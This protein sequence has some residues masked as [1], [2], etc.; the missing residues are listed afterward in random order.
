M[1]IFK[2]IPFI[3]IFILLN[4]ILAIGFMLDYQKPQCAQAQC[5]DMETVLPIIE[6]PGTEAYA[7]AR[8]NSGDVTVSVQLGQSR[9]SGNTRRRICF[10]ARTKMRELDNSS[11]KSECSLYEGGNWW[12]VVAKALHEGGDSDD[13]NDAWCTGTCLCWPKEGDNFCEESRG[14]GVRADNQ[15]E[16]GD[17]SRGGGNRDPDEPAEPY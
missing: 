11:E 10:L 5:A 16:P 7:T 1:K 4:L 8:Y 3:P 13:D 14:E 17:N 6:Y 12:Y 2:K 9:D 15:G